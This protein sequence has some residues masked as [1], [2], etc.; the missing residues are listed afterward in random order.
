MI[1]NRKLAERLSYEDNDVTY[2][3]KVLEQ[4]VPREKLIEVTNPLF[5]MWKNTVSDLAVGKIADGYQCTGSTMSFTTI[6][7]FQ[8][9]NIQNYTTGTLGWK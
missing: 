8:V 4:Q 7:P 5:F 3:F 6:N 9:I 1:V 2:N